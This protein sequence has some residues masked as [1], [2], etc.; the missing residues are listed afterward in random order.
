MQQVKYLHN[1]HKKIIDMYT[2]IYLTQHTCAESFQ[3]NNRVGFSILYMECFEP[4]VLWSAQPS[5]LF[6]DVAKTSGT[7]NKLKYQQKSCEYNQDSK[8]DIY[9]KSLITELKACMHVYH[10]PFMSIGQLS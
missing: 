9:R 4:L 10:S 2:R 8:I 1:L 7:V 5:T 6:V 3:H